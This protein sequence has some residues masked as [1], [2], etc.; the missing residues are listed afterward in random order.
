MRGR[1]VE[2]VGE[3]RGV[4][5][6][7]SGTEGGVVGDEAVQALVKVQVVVMVDSV[8]METLQ[9]VWLGF[10]GLMGRKGEDHLVRLEHPLMIQNATFP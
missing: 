3:G 5:G 8:E 9:A 4:A 7:V 1:M 10:G 2:G 6:K